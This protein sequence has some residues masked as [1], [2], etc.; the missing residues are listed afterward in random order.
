M[1]SVTSNEDRVERDKLFTV[2]SSTRSKGHHM[3]LVD[4]RVK[5]NN[6]DVVLHVITS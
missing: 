6:P 1:Y 3:K 2:I 4:V 5:F